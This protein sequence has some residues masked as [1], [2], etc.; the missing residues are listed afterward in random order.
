MRD[1]APR[2]LAAPYHFQCRVH[3]IEAF[4]HLRVAEAF[5][6]AVAEIRALTGCSTRVVLRSHYLAFHSAP[7]LAGLAVTRDGRPKA[8]ALALPGMLPLQNHDRAFGK[9][10]GL[11]CR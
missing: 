10:D 4:D 1:L 9:I 11:V 6:Q 7:W 5:G 8:I 2:L 3:R